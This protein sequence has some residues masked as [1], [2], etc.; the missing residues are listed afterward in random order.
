MKPTIF[1]CV[2]DFSSSATH[3][4][5]QGSKRGLAAHPCSRAK[6]QPS[7]A[8]FCSSSDQPVHL[9]A[10][11][12]DQSACSKRRSANMAAATA[13]AAAPAAATPRARAVQLAGR[14]AAPAVP[15]LACR[16]A[17]PQQQPPVIAPCL[18]C[19]LACRVRAMQQPA[20]EGGSTQQTRQQ[21]PHTR[22][23]KGEN[24]PHFRTVGG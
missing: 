8:G 13:G 18:R 24:P 4:T 20:N 19:R 1:T 6:P 10:S 14:A 3:T 5:L 11:I 9:T 17:L 2:R 21:R 23:S 22:A 16:R 15:P 12:A 7:L